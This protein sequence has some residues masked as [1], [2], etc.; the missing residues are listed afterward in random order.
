MSKKKEAQEILKQILCD[1]EYSE[2]LDIISMRILEDGTTDD[3]I[4][5][6]LAVIIDSAK[7]SYLTREAIN[8]LYHM[9]ARVKQ[10]NRNDL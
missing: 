10:E 4:E 3:L 1:N 9:T 2:K 8:Q 7:S 5:I 6:L